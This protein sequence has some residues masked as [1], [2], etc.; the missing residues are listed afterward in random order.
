MVISAKFLNEFNKLVDKYDPDRELNKLASESGELLSSITSLVKDKSE[1]AT[2]SSLTNSMATLMSLSSN[3]SLS[4]KRRNEILEF[5]CKAY[6]L[7]KE[8]DYKEVVEMDIEEVKKEVTT[9]RKKYQ[10]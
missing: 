9:F 6:A 2:V 10:C 5:N 7:I 4:P 8:I 3:V 1:D